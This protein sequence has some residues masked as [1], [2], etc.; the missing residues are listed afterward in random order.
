LTDTIMCSE[1]FF[2][3]TTDKIPTHGY[4]FDRPN[5][6]ASNVGILDNHGPKP[7]SSSQGNTLPDLKL[8]IMKGSW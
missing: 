4:I 8:K 5:V 6:H 1:N 3:L 7:G 2:W